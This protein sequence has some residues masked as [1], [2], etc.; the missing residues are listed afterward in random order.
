MKT[1]PQSVMDELKWD[2]NVGKRLEEWVENDRRTN[3]NGQY[4]LAD[5]SELLNLP[6]K[7]IPSDHLPI[8]A[9]F[10]FDD[11]CD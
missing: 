6:N 2:E 3:K 8:G 1:L 11:M 7:D 5:F 4:N 9:I 10:E